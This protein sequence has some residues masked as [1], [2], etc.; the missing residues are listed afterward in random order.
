MSTVSPKDASLF[1]N[2]WR[3]YL[4]TTRELPL[5]RAAVRVAISLS[6]ISFILLF[7]PDNILPSKTKDALETPLQ[8]LGVSVAALMVVISIVHQEQAARFTAN[9][10][11][12]QSLELES[13][14]LFR[15]E[16]ENFELSE[17]IW[18]EQPLVDAEKSRNKFRITQYLAQILNIFEMAVRFRKNHIMPSDVFGSWVIW[19]S[20]L[21]SSNT[22]RNHWQEMEP[23]LRWNYIPELREIIDDGLI[24]HHQNQEQSSLG[25]G[26]GNSSPD[27]ATQRFFEMIARKF[28]CD[29]IRNW[30]ERK[31]SW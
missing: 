31:P 26:G 2:A 15:Y 29:Q 4:K 24:I 5:V 11:V 22:F 21:C 8:L 10:Q 14:K 17:Y 28:D 23:D 30:F 16:M 9:H 1:N 20:D 3:D 18:I 13:I 25:L 6:L 12:Y 27:I 7:V 19:M